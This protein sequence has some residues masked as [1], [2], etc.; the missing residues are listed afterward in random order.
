MLVFK[1]PTTALH[2]KGMVYLKQE[3]TE[4]TKILKQHRVI[5]YAYVFYSITL[6]VQ[7]KKYS[8]DTRVKKQQSWI[9]AAYMPPLGNHLQSQ[10]YE[11][12]KILQSSPFRQLISMSG[13]NFYMASFPSNC[14]FGINYKISTLNCQKQSKQLR[15]K[16]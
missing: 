11:V 6:T 4:S 2:S 15:A 7:K 12:Y 3:H 16:H 13:N 1:S 5:N 14:F 9:K 10:Q 8:T